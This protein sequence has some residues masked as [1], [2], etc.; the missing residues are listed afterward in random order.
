MHFSLLADY[1]EA[2]PQIASWHFA[3][4]GHLGRVAGTDEIEA[5]LRESLNRDTMPLSILAFDNDE[6][7]GFAELKY[8]EMEIYPEKEH[9]LGGVFVPVEHRGK[10]VGCMVIRKSL[11]I[12]RS[13]GISTIFLQTEQ[14]DGGLYTG[15]GF[16]AVETVEYRGLEVLVMENRLD[17]K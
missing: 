16:V 3:E 10:G 9:W 6:I 14:L 11:D 1:P 15:L 7:V 17:D 13:L 4:W 2:I 5:K 8:H 12:A